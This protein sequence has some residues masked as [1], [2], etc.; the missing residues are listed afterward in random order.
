MQ[1]VTPGIGDNFGPVKEEVA[2]A[3]LLAL[4]EVAGDGAPG[5]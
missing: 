5:R 3:F 2:K 4:F 1:R